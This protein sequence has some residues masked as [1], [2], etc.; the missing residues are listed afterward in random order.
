MRKITPLLPTGIGERYCQTKPNSDMQRSCADVN[1]PYNRR[2][3]LTQ[4]AIWLIDYSEVL[5]SGIPR[6]R[7]PRISASSVAILLVVWIISRVDFTYPLRP[8]L[9]S[10]NN[11]AI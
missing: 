6:M 3:E 5:T 8:K 10:N 1:S 9:N 11:Q 2:A 4:G 7:M